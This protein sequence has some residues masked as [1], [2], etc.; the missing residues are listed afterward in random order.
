MM[1]PI[2]WIHGDDLSPTNLALMEFPEA[3]AVFVFDEPLIAYYQLSLKRLVFM[4]ECLLELPVEIRRGVV[5][6]E[7]IT[8]A[9]AHGADSVVTTF[10]VSP[11][12]QKIAEKLEAEIGP[13]KVLKPPSL[14][15]DL[16]YDLERF[17]RYWKKAEPSVCR[18]QEI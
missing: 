15:A 8:F 2:V 9:K 3:Q 4:Y 5:S 14:A 10:S 7:I 18:A 11:R 16:N 17:S 1:S 13:V 6:Q 12:F